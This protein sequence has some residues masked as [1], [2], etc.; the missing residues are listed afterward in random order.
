M[1]FGRKFSSVRDTPSP[2]A[3]WRQFLLLRHFQA[4]I[5]APPASSCT[6]AGEL[7]LPHIGELLFPTRASSS[8][9]T[10]VNSPT[11]AGELLLPHTGE[12][13][14][15][16]TGELL[17]PHTGK[18]PLPHT[19]ELLLSH[20]GE[21]LLPHTSELL[22]ATASSS[23]P[24]PASSRCACGERRVEDLGD[25]ILS[26]TSR[27]RRRWGSPAMAGGANGRVYG[28]GGR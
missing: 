17:L 22:H 20:T 2:E 16:H 3:A 25:Q 4:L 11:H 9:P 13:P 23:S 26:A 12:L 19:S 5:W 24:M 8:S 27:R 18:L 10:A 1:S 6:P 15:P 14:L 7:L 28:G 21:L